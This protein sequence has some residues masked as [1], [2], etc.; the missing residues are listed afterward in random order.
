MHVEAQDGTV[1][2]KQLGKTFAERDA[3]RMAEVLQALSPFSQLVLDFTR[4]HECHHGAFLSLV[5]LL[6]PLV[7][8]AVVL[9]GL[10]QHEARLLKYL[11]LGATEIRARA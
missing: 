4:V 6:Q 2:L 9:H 10:T 5:K 1:I 11:G 8:V 3:A 7:G